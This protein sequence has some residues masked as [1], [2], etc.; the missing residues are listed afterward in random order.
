MRV[1][2]GELAPRASDESRRLLV[3]GRWVNSRDDFVA[4]YYITKF[5]GSKRMYVF[6]LV[7]VFII[8]ELRWNSKGTR[9]CMF[10]MAFRAGEA[11]FIA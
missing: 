2:P 1:R 5:D 7:W 8:L 6:P 10:W 4:M 3:R 9:L 11:F